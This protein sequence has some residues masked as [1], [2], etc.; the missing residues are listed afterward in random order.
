MYHGQHVQNLTGIWRAYVR[1]PYRNK[2]EDA[3]Q[4]RR[5]NLRSDRLAATFIGSV[6][7]SLDRGRRPRL[8]RHL[9]GPDVQGGVDEPASGGRG[10]PRAW[11]RPLGCPNA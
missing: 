7:D 6:W 1:V 2:S 9:D 5:Y 11:L 10:S 3:E 4:S 8:L